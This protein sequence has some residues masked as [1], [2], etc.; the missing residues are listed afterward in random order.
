MKLVQII[1]CL[2]E[3]VSQ[4]VVVVENSVQ[5]AS[6]PDSQVVHVGLPL[7]AVPALRLLSWREVSTYY[8]RKIIRT[9]N[10][11]EGEANR[12]NCPLRAMIASIC[13]ARG[14]LTT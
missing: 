4:L 11:S 2:A 1:H 3:L 5:D 7:S 8:V 6:G 10:G 13:L 14:V 12:Q 9:V